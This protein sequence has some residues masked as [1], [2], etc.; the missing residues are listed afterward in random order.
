M[1]DCVRSVFTP[2]LMS[3]P[4]SLRGLSPLPGCAPRERVPD[5]PLTLVTDLCHSRRTRRARVRGEDSGLTGPRP[6]VKGSIV[7]GG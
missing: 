2:D 1:I 4:S 5:P 7:P 3:R 6:N